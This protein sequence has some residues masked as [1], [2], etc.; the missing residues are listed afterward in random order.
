[1]TRILNIVYLL[2][3]RYTLLC[4]TSPVN[5][6]VNCHQTFGNH[7]PGKWRSGKRLV[8]KKNHPGSVFPGN[9]F[10]GKWPL[11]KVTIRETTVSR[12]IKGVYYLIITW[13]HL[14]TVPW[15]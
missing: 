9:V 12:K 4:M 3:Y 7:F 6:G 10:P 2:N 14:Y 11:G 8:Q 1:M 13:C 5:F 15:I